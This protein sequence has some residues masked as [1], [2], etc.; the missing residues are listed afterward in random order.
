M[1][2]MVGPARPLTEQFYPTSQQIMPRQELQ[3][4]IPTFLRLIDSW[5]WAR[6]KA[7]IREQRVMKI[8]AVSAVMFIG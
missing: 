6:L 3:K 5:P 1:M 4:M 2:A 7:V 8:R